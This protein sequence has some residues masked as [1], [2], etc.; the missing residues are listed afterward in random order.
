MAH[1]T[2]RGNEPC[3]LPDGHADRHR[4]VR[5]YESYL[6]SK[7]RYAREYSRRDS[8]KWRDVHP[9]EAALSQMRVEAKRRGSP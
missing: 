8:A 9:V 6:A 2:T 4:T 3:A 1:L 7:R 5:N